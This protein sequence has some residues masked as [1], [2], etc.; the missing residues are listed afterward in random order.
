VTRILL[1]AAQLLAVASSPALAI[2]PT[3]AEIASA[4]EWLAARLGDDHK[5]PSAEPPFSFT[6]DGRPSREILE[7]WKAER[8]VRALD[9]ARTERVMTFTDPGTGLAL[10]WRAVE[11]CDF[12]TV[13]W[14]VYLKN[15]GQRDTPILENIQALDLHVRRDRKDGEFVLHHNQGS[16]TTVKDFQPF[17]APLAPGKELRLGTSGGRPMNLNMPY[18]NL[19]W[20]DQGMIVV[21]SW[22]GQWAASFNRD[23]ENG[24]R[25]AI[26]DRPGAALIVYRGERR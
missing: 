18:F 6:Y 14:T 24:L 5:A 4:H 26:P 11:Y 22:V 16:M 9:D 17:A 25:I 19:Q 2:H 13:E 20:G 10:T 8:H 23:A 1:L 21:V 7:T 3:Q 12:P 15:T